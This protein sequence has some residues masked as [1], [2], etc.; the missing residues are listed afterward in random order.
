[1]IPLVTTAVMDPAAFQNQNPLLV[2]ACIILMG[3]VLYFKLK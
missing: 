1:V 2:A 3:L